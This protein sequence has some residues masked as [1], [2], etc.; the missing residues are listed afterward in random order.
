ML[1]VPFAVVILAATRLAIEDHYHRSVV[2]LFDDVKFFTFAIIVWGVFLL[3]W[4][5]RHR[6]LVSSGDLAIGRVIK[7]PG[8]SQNGTYLRYE[9]TPNTGE[10]LSYLARQNVPALYPGMS[11]P[12]FYDHGNPHKKVALCAALYKVELPTGKSQSGVIRL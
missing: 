7:R 9:F 5:Y 8:S 3:G 10:R 1:A 12:V 11:L 6:R 4:Y 2:T